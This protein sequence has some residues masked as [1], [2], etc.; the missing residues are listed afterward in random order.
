MP[1]FAVT[2]EDGVPPGL[3]LD[4][5]VA[6]RLGL[7]TRSQVK[8]R[9]LSAKINGKDVK[10]SRTVREGDLLELS[11]T[12][13]PPV[14]LVPEN[15]P[16]DVLYEDGRVIVLNKPQGLVVHPGAGN[17]CG[18]LANALLYRCGGEAGPS[19]RPGIV[20]RLDKDTS[21]VMIAAKDEDALRFLAEQFRK[22]QVRKIYA[23]IVRGNPKEDRGRIATFIRRDGRNR[24]RFVVSEDGG[25]SAVTLYRVT[26]RWN[27]C[28]L[29]LL[30]PK[31]GRTHQ[32]RVHMR[33]LGN[34]IAG[35]PVYGGKE[36]RFAEAGL[37]LHARSL[38]LILPDHL[39]AQTFTAPVPRR[40]TCIMEKLEG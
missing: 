23:A 25:K 11:W 22:R 2:V 34:P 19:S 5:Y 3:R 40:F 12:D 8:A 6:E 10:I 14:F 24:K 35:D 33:W 20:H 26:R 17:R 13:A 29:V 7:L 4:R 38:S 1:S 36:D 31:T 18:T 21:G 28:A 39:E 30:M 32:L 9:F 16:L 15:I 27:G 37:M